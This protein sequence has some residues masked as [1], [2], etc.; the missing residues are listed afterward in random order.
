MALADIVNEPE[1]FL[2]KRHWK[3]VVHDAVT[4]LACGCAYLAFA[5]L[6]LLFFARHDFP[7]AIWPATGLLVGF[8]LILPR[9]LWPGIAAM[10][11]FA[12]TSANFIAGKPIQFAAGL[13]LMDAVEGLLSAVF[14]TAFLGKRIR[15]ARLREFTALVLISAVI[16][17]GIA[18]LGGAGFF[19]W[20]A[21]ARFW[22]SWRQWW[23][24][25]G[26]GVLTVTPFVVSW[27]YAG[28]RSLAHPGKP[29]IAE[30]L[31]LLAVMTATG[32]AIFGDVSWSSLSLPYILFPFL[33]WAALR[34]GV[35]GAS[36]AA[37]VL[38]GIAVWYTAHGYGPFA[39]VS[40]SMSQQ[41]LQLQSFVCA[42]LACSLVPAMV[43]AERKEAEEELRRS[44]SRL[45]MAQEI[46]GVGDFV[47][48][49][50]GQ[51]SRWSEQMAR[52]MGRSPAQPAP[53]YGEFLAW[54]HPEDREAVEGFYHGIFRECR[55]F[56]I[57]FRYVC[58]DGSWKYLHAIARPEE[59]KDTHA[60][61]A[62]GTILDLT[63]RRKMEEQLRQAQKMEAIGQLAGGVAH[64]FNN[65]LGVILGYADLALMQLKSDDPMRTKI[66]P[67]SQAAGRAATLTAQLLAFSRKQVLK[68]EPVDL[69]RAVTDLGK[70]LRRVIGEQIEISTELEARLP[71][72]KADPSQIDQV[73]LNL[74]VNAKDAMPG[75]GRLTISTA[76]MDVYTPP[77]GYAG[78]IA[79]GEYVRLTVSDTGHGMDAATQLHIFE[80]FFTTK[81]KGKGTGLGLATVYGIVAQS[82]GCIWAESELGRGTQFHILLPAMKGQS[83][84]KQP[85][86]ETGGGRAARKE[87]LLVV[88]DER[89]LRE[90]IVQVVSGMGCT[91]IEA[92]SGQ[93][94]IEIAQ[95]RDDIDVLLTDVV[96]PKMDGFELARRIFEISPRIK[97]L[98]MSGYSDEMITRHHQGADQPNFI[99]KP[100]RPEELHGK[101]QELMETDT[102]AAD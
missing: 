17:G 8:M 66:E 62:F 86:T 23:L 97:V 84:V 52:I 53:S 24:A 61:N 5:L 15:F 98:Y 47:L 7:A 68:P 45:A 4:V 44:E 37:L 85:A 34:F 100:F 50:T 30:L 101:L 65:L 72:V 91:V 10:A 9:R 89:P 82:N 74:A 33:I 35:E 2:R 43:M 36:A 71:M 26:I 18:A 6:A 41:L 22:D 21:G 27:S 49:P 1:E 38:A 57:D 29:K 79:P 95:S 80:P 59:D 42:A 55:P 39:I 99:Q 83:C 32:V 81:G 77:P 67:I 13:A 87:T 11:F 78:Q 19:N 20:M 3:G 75:G 93:N 31:I 90:L 92:F 25:H 76:L 88:E 14:L 102:T 58:P 28:R 60:L 16:T 69:N 64:D 56:Q 12:A 63:D 70:M 73:M 48:D 54:V 94:A 51:N 96:M 40:G 46:A